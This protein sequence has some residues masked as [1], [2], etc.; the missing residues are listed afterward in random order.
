MGSMTTLLDTNRYATPVPAVAGVG[1]R[2]LVTVAVLCATLGDR[3]ESH[4]RLTPDQLARQRRR[5]LHLATDV[6][7]VRD[8]VTLG[9]GDSDFDGDLPAGSLCAADLRDAF[10]ATDHLV[11]VR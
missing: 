5:E 4:L 11:R 7:G 2:L 1:E 8:V 9:Y 3:G 10:L 6:L